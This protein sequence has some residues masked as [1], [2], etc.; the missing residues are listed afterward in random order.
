MD[1]FASTIEV[2]TDPALGESE[3][4]LLADGRELARVDAARGTPQHP[5]SAG[6]LRAKVRDL[7]GSRLDGVLDDAAR[8]AAELLAAL[9]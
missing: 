4:A 6:D 2:R 3:F 8:P 5:L 7:A 1:S 9:A